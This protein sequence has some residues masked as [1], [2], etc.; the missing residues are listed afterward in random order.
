MDDPVENT[1]TA[2]VDVDEVVAAAMRSDPNLEYLVRGLIGA[3]HR[4][5][6]GAYEAGV[7][8]EHERIERL[9]MGHDPIEP[10][11]RAYLLELIKRK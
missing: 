8:Y 4:R 5:G 9:I 3:A 7:R 1:K 6:M 11:D 10:S 2:P